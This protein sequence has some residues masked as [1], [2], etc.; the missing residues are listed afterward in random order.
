[1]MY[2]SR[3][4]F[5]K[6]AGGLAALTAFSGL[7]DSLSAAKSQKLPNFVVIF[8]D[9]QGYEDVGCFGAEGFETPN[10]DKM[11]AEGMR[12]TD[13]H[14]SQSVC[15]P[16]RAALMT[17]CYHPRVGIYKAFFPHVNRGLNP[18]EE[19]I[20]EVLK[21]RGY[22]CGIFGKWHLGHRYPFLPLQ[23]GFDE[24]FGLPYSN[25]MW[26]RDFDGTSLKDG[27]HPKAR[28]RIGIPDLPLMKGN[29]IIDRIRT[30]EDQSKLTTMYTERAVDFIERNKSE[31]FFLYLPHSMPHVPLAVSDKFRGKSRK[32]IYGD[33]IMEIDWSAGE[34]FKAL[35]RN[36]L[37]ENTLVIFTSDNGPWLNYGKHGGSADPL[38]EGKGSNCW[39]G[40]NRVPCIMRWPGKIPASSVCDKLAGAIDILPT[41]ATLSG[42]S[43][44]KKKI[45]GVDITA[46]LEGRENAE[47]RKDY[48]YYYEKELDAV[49]RGPWKLVFPHKYRGC[50]GVEP[51]KNGFPGP[52][53]LRKAEKG[54]YNLNEDI[55]EEKNVINEHPEIVKELEKLAESAREELGDSLH[56][57][58]GKGQRPVGRI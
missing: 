43:L 50:E 2:S 8:T 28:W 10:L 14:V 42:A 40:G 52:R 53:E 35:K 22:R 55:E 34:I 25:D 24:Y 36:G 57:I 47:P 4:N 49:R 19:T 12:F 5:L 15:S 18:K 41:F 58:R 26:P 27:F 56:N 21:P 39:E 17:G 46:L 29:T 1:M 37:D 32:G 30:M 51:G 44:P 16:S 48:F 20:A 31:P 45:D 33:V 11:A 6:S 3:R 38:R 13:F 9:D 7:A 23:Q 54:L